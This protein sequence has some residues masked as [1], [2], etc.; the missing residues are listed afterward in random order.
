MR[1][2]PW[3]SVGLLLLGAGGL[4][5]AKAQ[6]AGTWD[7]RG[8]E[9][10]ARQDY[11]AAYEDY[12]KAHDKKPKDLRYEEHFERLRFLAAVQHVDRG[13][14]L[15]QNGDWNGAMQ[16]FLRAREIDP[17]NQTAEQEIMITQRD[18]P[19]PSLTGP[20][21]AAAVQEMSQQA[22]VQQEIASIA[23][24]ISLKPVSN[25]PITLHMVEDVKNIYQAI[26]KLAGL[27]V[28]FDPDYTSKRI[29]IDLTNVTLAEALRIVGT[30][31]GT[32]YKPVTPNTIFV[33]QNNPP[34]PPAPNAPIW[35]TWRCRRFTCR[36][37]RSRTMATKS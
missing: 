22:K 16:Q 5:Q 9:A 33:A 21:A 12:K 24:P 37:A 10:E 27:N 17:S 18:Q 4:K 35:T 11:D 3:L 23:G 28:I 25:D 19:A 2:L 26:G 34:P 6:S 30:V 29:P 8:G 32:F 20:A 36:T 15:R 1:T 7:K 13:R 14:L 31:S